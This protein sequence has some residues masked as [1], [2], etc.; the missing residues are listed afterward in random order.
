MQTEQLYICEGSVPLETELEFLSM[1]Q[2]AAAWRPAN[3]LVHLFSQLNSAFPNRNRATDGLICDVNHEQSSDHCPHDF[4]GWGNDIVTAGDY[5]HDPA[6]GCDMRVISEQ[7]RLSRDSRI[8]YV[9]FNRRI[10]LDDD[11]VWRPYSGTNPHDRHMHLSVDGNSGSDST[12]DWSIGVALTPGEIADIRLAVLGR[13]WPNTGQTLAGTVE[14]MKL[15][16]RDNLLPAAAADE[17]RDAATLAAINAFKTSNDALLTALAASMQALATAEAGRDEETA[18][19]VQ[20]ILTLAQAGSG[21]FDV[22]AVLAE[23]RSQATGTN[24]I[25]EN[26][27]VQQDQ[28]ETQVIQLQTKVDEQTALINEIPQD[29]LDAAKQRLE[30]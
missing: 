1:A 16:I 30:N 11:W 7:L 14:A 27:L 23:I 28:L 2:L 25:V 6:N 15:W 18:A 21:S 22:Q 3:S 9:I 12:R 10:F 29:V 24:S 20:T 4:P 19:H 5:T 8:K 17:T 13:E 26:L